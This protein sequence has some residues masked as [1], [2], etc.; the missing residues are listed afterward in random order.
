MIGPKK[1]RMPQ[2]IGIAEAKKSQKGTNMKVNAHN[3]A[4]IR[5]KAAAETPFILHKRGEHLH[6]WS[7]WNPNIRA[8]TE[9]EIIIEMYDECTVA[10][11]ADGKVEVTTTN[12]RLM[13]QLDTMHSMEPTKCTGGKMTN[14]LAVYKVDAEAWQ[15]YLAVHTEAKPGN[16][17]S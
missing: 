16:D 4:A 13:S 12:R 17:E 3:A 2:M 15:A 7:A 5:R 1:L 8:M 10:P 9:Q 14:G 6:Q 11:Q